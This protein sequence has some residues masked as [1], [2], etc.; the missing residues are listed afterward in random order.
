VLELTAILCGLDITRYVRLFAFASLCC[1]LKLLTF[2]NVVCC[3]FL[4]GEDRVDGRD[5]RDGM[6]G[7][8]K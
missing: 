7:D 1:C 2:G 3:D 6:M 5:E 4:D 8:V